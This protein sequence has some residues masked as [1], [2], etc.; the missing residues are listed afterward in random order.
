[1][2]DVVL[3]EVHLKYIVEKIVKSAIHPDL[4]IVNVPHWKSRLF[5][6]LNI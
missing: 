1:M 3:V 6:G 4:K 5:R 2:L